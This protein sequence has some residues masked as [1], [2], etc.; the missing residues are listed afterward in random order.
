MFP[1]PYV[2]LK[3]NLPEFRQEGL[4]CLE[5]LGNLAAGQ[6]NFV[7]DCRRGLV[8]ERWINSQQFSK[9][10]DRCLPKKASRCSRKLSNS[11]QIMETATRASVTKPLVSILIPAYNA[12]KSIA[13]T[14]QSAGPNV[15]TKGDHCR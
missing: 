7:A 15:A 1:V 9:V 8:L 4:R 6:F 2:S 11:E 5:V 3:V 13:D 14:L 12:E 10:L